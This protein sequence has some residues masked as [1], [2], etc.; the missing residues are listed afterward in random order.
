MRDRLQGWNKAVLPLLKFSPSKGS[1]IIFSTENSVV[2]KTTR[3]QFTRLVTL[4]PAVSQLTSGVPDAGALGFVQGTRNSPSPD[5]GQSKW[6]EKLTAGVHLDYHYPE[7]D[8]YLIS[9]ADGAQI[10]Q[11]MAAIGSELVVV[12]G[13]CHYGNSY[14]NTKVGHKHKNLGSRDLLEEW[15][16]EARKRKITLL[17]YYSVNR[18]VWAGQQ[19]PEWRM[20]DAE[21][22]I[23]DED[24]WPPEWASMG[25]LLQL[26]LPG[27]CESA[28]SRDHGVRRRRLPLRH[29]L[30]WR[31]RQSLLLQRILPPLV[32]Q[33]IR[34]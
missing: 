15:A 34:H 24:R 4:A 7:W 16:R 19:H 5:S 1:E 3:R 33:K 18:D 17:A 20:K 28:G 23:V 10:I 2:M 13:K 9:K 12:F 14:Y 32:S 25:F 30:V 29:A 26:T 22:R 11:R 6:F 27:L 8:P 31:H 21:G